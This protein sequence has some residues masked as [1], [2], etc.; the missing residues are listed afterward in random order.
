MMLTAI[1]YDPVIIRYD[2]ILSDDECDHLIELARPTLARSHVLNRS[3]GGNDVSEIRTS[4][5][6]YF[7][8]GHT[9]IIATIERRIANTILLPIDRAEPFQVMRYRVGGRYDAHHDFFDPADPGSAVHL[10]AGGQRIA[11]MILYLNT[12]E[13][14]GTTD[15]PGLGLSVRPERGSAL[16]FEYSGQGRP[17]VRLRHGGMPVIQGEKWIATK[18][19][20]ERV[21]P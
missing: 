12:P 17:D 18:W 14:G 16:Y 8:R 20:R 15:F 7:P 2:Q 21:Y 13:A 5:G 4:E 11:T 9:E 10:A 1:S 6:A 3:T 19:F